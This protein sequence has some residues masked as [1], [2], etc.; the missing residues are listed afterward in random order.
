MG[1]QN[2]AG[3]IEKFYN[4][5]REAIRNA[6]HPQAVAQWKKYGYEDQKVWTA[7]FVTGQQD[8][9]WL[10]TNLLDLALVEKAHRPI[11]NDFFIKKNPYIDAKSWKEAVAK[12]S[13][14]KNRMLLYSRGTFKSSLDVADMV[15]WF[16]VFPNIRIIVMTA[17]ST[18][19]EF[20]VQEVKKHFAVKSGECPT[21]F[22]MLYAVFCVEA[23]KRESSDEFSHALRT[24]SGAS[25][26]GLSLGMS[27]AGKHADIGKFDDCV[28]DANSGAMATEDSRKTVSNELK[29]KRYIVDGYGYRDYVGTI[30]D[31]DDGYAAIQKTLPDLHVL[32]KSAITLKDE[33]RAKK[34]EE[35]TELDYELLFPMDGQGVERWTYKAL[36][37]EKQIDEYI[38]SC[39]ILLEP[40]SFRTVKFT[41]ALLRSHVVKSEGLPQ[42]GTF[43]TLM[44]WDFAYSNEKGRDFSVGTIA[45]FC[46]AGP[47]A[48]KAFIVDMVRG[49]FSKSELAMNV[50]KLA[51]KWRPEKIGIEKS[52]GADFLENDIMREIHRMGFHDCP[53]FEWFPVD[54]NKDAATSRAEGLETLLISDRLYFSAEIPIL[55]D[56]IKEF[57]VFKPGSKRKNDSVDSIAHACRYLPTKIE[58][59]QT[60]QERNQAVHDL[61]MQKHLNEIIFIPA[62]KPEAPPE[63][64]PTS[65]EGQPVYQNLEQMYLGT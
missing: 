47:L 7:D 1:Q 33:S 38:Y 32:R 21:R 20:F 13:T 5:S 17:E 55:D 14:I 49:R 2:W 43:T 25:L 3:D 4:T 27:T 54:S 60:E 59:P 23:S 52:N 40:L 35:L 53:Q 22:Q 28:S 10:A 41:E 16:L 9:Y 12:Q 46:L 56:V 65:W 48:G 6:K 50:A 11:T 15:Q 45:W 37:A 29:T 58:I 31:A 34:K 64:P 26:L 30:Y 44:S 63:P 51:T 42:A 57:V 36:M 8:L 18:L 62:P 19:A 24:D 61:L 39:Q